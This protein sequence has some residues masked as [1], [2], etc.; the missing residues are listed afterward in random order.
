[1]F[2]WDQSFCTGINIIDEQHKLLFKLGRE[3]ELLLQ[4]P[5]GV[6]KK[7]DALKL[8]VD[9]RDYVTFHFYTEESLMEQI[10]YPDIEHHREYHKIFQNQITNISFKNINNENYDEMRTLLNNIYSWIFDHM[11][12]ED[13]YFKE[14]AENHQLT[15]D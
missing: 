14:Y 13:L 8:L 15:H 12:K 11:L 7:D 1:M 9:L 2:S 5:D 3:F 4:I 6:S 10:D